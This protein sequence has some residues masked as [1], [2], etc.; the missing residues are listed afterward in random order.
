MD[1][2]NDNL[3]AIS[4]AFAEI[5]KEYSNEDGIIDLESD[6]FCQLLLN[7]LDDPNG[8]L[9]SIHCYIDKDPVTKTLLDHF[10]VFLTNEAGEGMLVFSKSGFIDFYTMESSSEEVYEEEKAD[11]GGETP[12][13]EEEGEEEEGESSPADEADLGGD[14]EGAAGGDEATTSGGG[15]TAALA[16]ALAGLEPEEREG[17]NHSDNDSGFETLS[18]NEA[19]TE[20]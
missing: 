1:L 20:Y 2:E 6:E 11:G 15:R 7:K 9:V 18:M 19:D 5:Y 4:E 14:E 13:E 16:C 10:Q 8:E 17:T 12:L 3:T